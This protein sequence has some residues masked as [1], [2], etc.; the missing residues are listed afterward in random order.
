MLPLMMS[1]IVILADMRDAKGH[2]QLVGKT[3]AMRGR[4]S[5]RDRRL[6]S[7]LAHRKERDHWCGLRLENVSVNYEIR[8]LGRGPQRL[9]KQ[10]LPRTLR[11]RAVRREKSHQLKQL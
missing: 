9:L 4:G 2:L 7:D 11:K 10:Q 6:M 1:M 5:M 3:E 8:L